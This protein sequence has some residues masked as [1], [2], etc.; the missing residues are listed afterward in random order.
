[1]TE[2]T[3]QE[4]ID[5]G[6]NESGDDVTP[7]DAQTRELSD[8]ERLAADMGW[9]PDGDGVPNE[10]R[11][12]AEAWIKEER[13]INRSLKKD[14]RSMREQINRM[15]ETSSKQTERAL[16]RQAD[17]LQARF[18]DAVENR[19]TQGA[20][21]AMQELNN[22]QAEAVNIAPTANVEQDFASRNPWYGKDDDATAYA[23]AVSQREHAKGKSAADQIEAVEAAIRKRFPELV[24]G[25][26]TT[27]APA[28]V[29]APS[30]ATSVKRARG[31][32]DLPADVKRAAESYAKLYA[33][34]FGLNVDESKKEYAKDYWDGQ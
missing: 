6:A 10:K 34:K 30:R 14:M 28:A 16:K 11:K 32:D 21:R 3:E 33:E 15:A 9:R 29:N 23:V 13:E 19:D 27:K 22:L 8:V 5:T 20:A 4:P 18:A 1:M 24:G 31:Y 7:P 25:T 17:E 26:S 12:S 2:F